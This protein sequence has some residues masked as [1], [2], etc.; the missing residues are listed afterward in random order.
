MWELVGLID[1]R[2]IVVDAGLLL[3]LMRR[4]GG[5]GQRVY[6]RDEAPLPGSQEWIGLYRVRCVLI[7]SRPD[8]ARLPPPIPSCPS[9][10][11]FSQRGSHVAEHAVGQYVLGLE[12][13]DFHV[14]GGSR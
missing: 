13:S 6:G 2:F 10:T 11:L 14:T 9:L 8:R 3:V 1:A 7:S 12:T 5:P 4:A